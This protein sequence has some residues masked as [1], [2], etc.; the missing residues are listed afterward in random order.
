MV[1]CG[2]RAGLRWQLVLLAAVSLPAA[3]ALVQDQLRGPRLA[4]RRPT[5][6]QVAGAYALPRLKEIKA[7]RG[8]EQLDEALGDTAHMKSVADVIKMA[9]VDVN[10]GLSSDEVL[11]RREKYGLNQLPTKER[12]PLWK[13]FIAQFDDKMVHI[14]LAAAGISVFFSMIDTHAEAHPFVEPMVIITILL[15]NA[16]IGVWQESNAESAI[17]ALSTYNPDQVADRPSTCTRPSTDCTPP[18][19]LVV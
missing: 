6:H 9:A 15:L 17:E 4:V 13:R 10:Q 19:P 16:C 11:A 8:G 5:Q 1:W 2:R 14:L 3:S 12:V 18:P 7:L